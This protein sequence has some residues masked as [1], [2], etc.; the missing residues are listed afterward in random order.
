[1]RFSTYASSSSSFFF[2]AN[3]KPNAPRRERIPSAPAARSSLVPVFGNVAWL[4]ESFCF[5]TLFSDE[6]GW[7]FEVTTSGSRVVSSDGTAVALVSVSPVLVAV[8]SASLF[9]ATPPNAFLAFVIAD[10]ASFTSVCVA[11][12]LANTSLPAVTAWSYAAF[13]LASAL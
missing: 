4:S 7:E 10:T 2:L 13:L 1:M 11:L 9:V 6:T 3:S 8:R 12:S 5:S